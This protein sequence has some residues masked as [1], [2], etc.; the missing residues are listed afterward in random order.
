M[1]ELQKT[2]EGLKPRP[3]ISRLLKA[4]ARTSSFLALLIKT[5]GIF[6]TRSEPVRSAGYSSAFCLS[7][8]TDGS[9]ITT[10]R[11]PRHTLWITPG[12]NTMA[13]PSCKIFDSC[14]ESPTLL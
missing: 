3:S 5:R 1:S 11:P 13:P 7:P 2:S 10:V 9:S 12:P 14:L 8:V 4:N 6:K